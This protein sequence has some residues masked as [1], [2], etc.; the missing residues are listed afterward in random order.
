MGLATG[1]AATSLS[2]RR[3]RRIGRHVQGW[4][5][6]APWILGFVIFVAGPMLASAVMVFT[7]WDLLSPA[8]FA[9]LNNI[10]RL[11][12]HDPL[13]GHSLK[14][15][16]M[17]AIVS[18][19]MDIAAGL[20]L[21]MLLNANIRGLRFYRTLYYLPVVLSGV[22][23]A[24]LWR[25]L[26]SPEFGP[27]NYI[28]SLFGIAGPAW[29]LDPEWAMPA[30]VMMTLW[31]VGGGMVIYLAALQGVPTELYEAS[32]VDG[33]G[34]WPRLRFITLPM[35]TPVIFFQ[36]VMGIIRSLQVFTPAFIMT[37]GGPLNATLFYELY[38]YRIAFEQFRM[39]F[40][41]AMA[42]LLFLYI[43]VLTLLVFRSARSWVYYE[44]EQ[45]GG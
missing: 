13:V 21:A 15:T 34:W 32:I 42:W 6:A 17:Y 31:S 36:L 24:L 20:T 44:G 40:A 37:Q 12:V 43:L 45:R 26:F 2:S 7:D 8:R 30:L 29:L 11:F 16:T 23:S 1:I 38:L 19:P 35:I 25:W 22:A 10:R 18:V 5:F 3:R 9:G 28:L 39:G 4:L 27:L 33:A 14:I 41:S